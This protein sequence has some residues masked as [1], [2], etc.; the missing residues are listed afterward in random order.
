M[1]NLEKR[2]VPKRR[3]KEFENAP[4]WEQHKLGDLGEIK[5]GIG[6]P[7]NEQGGKN[8]IPFYKVSD[9]NSPQNKIKM[10]VSNNYVSE[11]Q[12]QN[13]K[14]HI[15]SYIPSLIFAKIG[16]ALTL[17]RKRLVEH[18]FLIDNNTMAY[19]LSNVW[20]KYFA[21]TL[22]QN[23]YLP[24]YMQVGALPSLGGTDI[25]MIKVLIPQIEEQK[26][27]GSFFNQ[28]DTLITLQQRKLNKLNNLKK[29]YL[30]EMFPAEGERKPKRR[31]A[32]FTDDWEQ[33]ELGDNLKSIH[34]GTSL[35]GSDS[36]LGMP[37]LKMGNINRGY[38]SL[39]KIEFL[40]KDANIDNLDLVKK[41]DFL[42]NTRNTLE[43]VGKGATWTG[44]S[45]NYAFNSNIARFTFKGIDTVFFNYLY[46]T[47]SMI[48]QIHSRATGTTSV[49]A[50]Y[51]RDIVSI[52]YLIPKLTEQKKI[53]C[54]F[55]QLD[56]LITLHQRKIDKLKKLKDA[57]LNEMFV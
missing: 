34:T 4:A 22:F 21:I 43:L 50:V 15:I 1:S 40:R 48:K 20:N 51:P 53:G 47:E 42:F 25:K 30:A 44:T 10:T 12:I 17:D 7:E 9:M 6:F 49:A 33:R 45:D 26:Q 23:I 32:G 24:K 19:S 29:S 39:N 16:A 38:F 56:N 54:F 2:K 55:N 13:K 31:F 18:P 8:G 36:N 5:S 11:K 35:L 57:Y 14:W 37:L 28:L 41:G 27:I 3:F 46:N 52:S